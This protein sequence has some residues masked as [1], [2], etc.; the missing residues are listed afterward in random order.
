[1]IEDVQRAIGSLR[2][3]MG[4]HDSGTSGIFNE[5]VSP[6][7]I[8]HRIGLDAD[9]NLQQTRRLLLLA[10]SVSARRVD[11]HRDFRR[12]I[13]ERYEVE[14]GTV[15][16]FLINDAMRYW[17]TL[18]VDYQA[19]VWAGDNPKKWGSR[20][21]KF[22][23]ARKILCASVVALALDK[24]G[25]DDIVAE[26]AKAP[27]G[28]LVGLATRTGVGP[29]ALARVLHAMET[30]A[31]HL[32]DASSREEIDG[33]HGR[34]TASPSQLFSTLEDAGKEL[35]V[36]LVELFSGSDELQHELRTYLLF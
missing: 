22:L 26:L 31:Y 2:Q 12:A 17:R 4:L 21:L 8:V 33:W 27:V 11:A 30:F 3:A 34:T 19:K 15:S 25:P 18:A 16:R 23:S 28:R 29:G 32:D 13:V 36:A 5:I 6:V 10:E 9:T 20:Y 7:D 24:L 35:H 14:A 1:M